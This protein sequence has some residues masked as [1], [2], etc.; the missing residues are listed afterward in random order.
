MKMIGMFSENRQEW[1]ITELA[2]CS[3]SIVT[4]PIAVETQFLDT[5]RISHILDFTEVKTLCVS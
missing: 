1:F 2:A 3:H 5:Q 4:V